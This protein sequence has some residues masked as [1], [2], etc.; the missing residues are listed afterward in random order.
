[1]SAARLNVWVTAVG[2]P[3]RIDNQHQWFVHVLHCNGDVLE[4]CDRRYVNIPTRCG[5]ADI[6]LPPGCYTVCATWS[7]APPTAGPPTSL[8]NHISH[9]TV[10]RADCGEHV[11][12]T[13]FP[14]TFHWCGIW[15]LIAARQAVEMK[16]VDADVVKPAI[17]AMQ[18]V[19]EAIEPDPF[20]ERMAV[21]AESPEKG[22]EQFRPFEDELL[23]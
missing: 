1:M 12:V 14:P 21:V 11:C 16:L 2:D 19:T 15:W 9:L 23:E 22:G 13:L 20:A 8:G 17:E 7:P 4:W 6:P 18:R 5:H 10:V 3:C